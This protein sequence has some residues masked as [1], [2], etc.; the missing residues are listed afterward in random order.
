MSFIQQFNFFYVAFVR[1]RIGVSKPKNYTTTKNEMAEE[2]MQ[3]RS[4]QAPCCWFA[5]TPRTPSA[6]PSQ[7]HSNTVDNWGRRDCRLLCQKVDQRRA[8]GRTAHA[9]AWRLGSIGLKKSWQLSL[10]SV[11]AVAAHC[12]ID[13]MID[14]VTR[15]LMLVCVGWSHQSSQPFVAAHVVFLLHEKKEHHTL[16]DQ[17]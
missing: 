3:Q 4:K 8:R 6:L 9:R 10:A 13:T 2:K 5:C 7:R 14:I 15:S 16:F 1:T 17:S 11:T 12:W